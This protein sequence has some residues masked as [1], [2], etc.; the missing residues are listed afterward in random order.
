MLIPQVNCLY[1]TGFIEND[2]AS[3]GNYGNT[4]IEQRESTPVA[5][6]STNSHNFI[7]MNAGRRVLHRMIL[8]TPYQL[9]LWEFINL[10]QVLIMF[11]QVVS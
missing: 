3:V 11:L 7:Q 9:R 5:M 8:I 1:F 2:T 10:P 6:S 4:A